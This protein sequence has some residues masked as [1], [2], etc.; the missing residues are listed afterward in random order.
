MNETRQLTGTQETPAV[1]RQAEDRPKQRDAFFDNAKYLAIVLVAVGHAW[2]PLRGDSRVVTALYMAVYAFHMPAFIVISGYLSRNFDGR[3]DR[4]QRLVTG[5]LVPYVVFQVAYTLFLRRLD[6]DD[7]TYIGLFE[8]R[9]LLWFL[10]ALFIWRLTVPVWKALR[11]PLPFALAIAAIAT[12]SPSLGNDLQIQRV[13]QFLP[14]FVLGLVL[15]PEHFQRVRCRA[16]RL[17]A[18]PV[19]AG[20]L[21]VAYWAVPRMR[22]TWFYHRGS[23]QELGEPWWT[24]I[25]MTFVLFACSV[26]LTACFFALVPG[27]HR[28]FTSLGAGTL[29]GLLLHGFLVRGAESWGWYD[30]DVMHEQPAALLIASAIA[31]VGVTLLCTPVVQRIFRPL[32]EPRL[33]WLFR[34]RPAA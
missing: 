12:A 34:R 23:A 26:L 14:F 5:V 13:L 30:P 15:K 11:W 20:A 21:L 29:Y 33:D 22:Y 8:P 6:D 28:W 18:V 16:V 4:V 10:L 9:W 2:E 1:P 7:S 27:R 24:G 19:F 17:L 31:A 32:V 25:V 3:A